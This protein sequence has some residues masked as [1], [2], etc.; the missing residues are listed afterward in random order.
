MSRMILIVED[1]K[2]IAAWVQTYFERAGFATLVAHDGH[3][4]IELARTQAPDLIILDLMLPKMGGMA[5]CRTL[6]S[7]SDV[8]IIMLTAKGTQPDRIDGLETGADDYIVKPFDPNEVVARAKAVLRRVK[9]RAQ[10]RLTCGAI[11][12]NEETGQVSVAGQPV[13]LSQ[14][15]FS[16]LA[17][18]MR[19]PNQLLSRQQLIAFAF[20]NDYDGYDRAI[21]THIRR[22]RKQLAANG[23]QPIETVYGA[24]YR[25]IV[26]EA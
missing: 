12:L 22:L 5:V 16:L 2:R 13:T 18:F 17:T 11:V 26:E 10:R 14:S 4:G 1:E 23:K 6:R 19:H 3:D 24:G 21:D 15:Q 7:E 8:P 20:D 25:L 9:G